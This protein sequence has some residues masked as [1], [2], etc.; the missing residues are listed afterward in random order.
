MYFGTL[1]RTSQFYLLSYRA[2]QLLA[3]KFSDCTLLA[4]RWGISIWGIRGGK[5]AVGNM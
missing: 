4:S 2:H 3:G 5:V 1:A